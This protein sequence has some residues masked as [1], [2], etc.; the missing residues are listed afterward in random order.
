MK[1]PIKNIPNISLL[2]RD[3]YYSFDK[4]RKFYQDDFRDLKAFQEQ[5][6]RI[7]SRE[8]PREQLVSILK[9]QNM[10]YGCENQTLDNIDKFIQDQACAVVTGQQAGLFS[11]PLYTVYKALTAIK[12]AE[13]LSHSCQGRFLPVFWLASDDHDFDEI[14]HIMV[15]SKKN[16]ISFSTCR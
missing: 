5:A 9:R 11:G 7:M 1:I 15:M 3:Y 16:Q 13:K 14:N 6:Q 4:V 8:L 2:V 12:L 10:A